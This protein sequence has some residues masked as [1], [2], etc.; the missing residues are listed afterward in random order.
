MKADSS[1]TLH[2]LTVH[3]GEKQVLG[4]CFQFWD[5]QACCR[6][7]S[8]LES[9]NDI[10]NNVFMITTSTEGVE[11]A[12]GKRLCTGADE[13]LDESGNHRITEGLGDGASKKQQFG[14]VDRLGHN[15]EHD[16][17]VPELP[18]FPLI[19]NTCFEEMPSNPKS[20]FQVQSSCGEPLLQSKIIT[21]KV[22]ALYRDGEKKL[23]KT[24]KDACLEG[25]ERALKS[26]DQH[27]KTVVILYCMECKKV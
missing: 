22:M 6:V 11:I 25:H 17:S 14:F 20:S 27:D 26:Y 1:K 13:D 21:A 3:L 24:L 18:K 12:F 23:R 8:Y 16:A 2:D 9:L 4:Y 10:E 5:V 7:A 19:D 15:E